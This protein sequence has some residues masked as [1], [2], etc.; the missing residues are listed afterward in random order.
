MQVLDC[1]KLVFNERICDFCGSKDSKPAQTVS[2][3]GLSF[4]FVRCLSCDLVYQNPLLS[5]ESRNHLYETREYWSN[6]D[7]RLKDEKMLNYY[8]Y[9]EEAENRR[10]TDK[11]RIKWLTSRIPPNSRV[12]DLGCGDG[13][14]VDMLK[15]SGF[16]AYGMDISSAMIAVA[17][18]KYNVEIIRG[19]AEKKWDFA[20]PFDAIVCYTISNFINPSQVFKQ[21]QMNLRKG[22]Y[23]F[24]NFADCDN[25]LSRLLGGRFYVYRPSA[26]IAYSKKTITAYCEKNGLQIESIKNDVQMIPL[27]RFFGMLGFPSFV[28]GLK[29]T[30]IDHWDIKTTLPTSY[31]ACAVRNE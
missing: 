4:Q 19:D 25:L 26:A 11:F 9:V 14:Y 30:G 16:Q 7:G 10:K 20:E 24:F 6:K 29:F 18:E 3:L 1:S 21:I 8:S 13:L 27:V 5:S 22:G 15:K 31:I 12:L 23:F 28:E 2:F 17:K